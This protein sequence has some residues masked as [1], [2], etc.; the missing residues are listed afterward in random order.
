MQKDKYRLKLIYCMCMMFFAF[1]IGFSMF[2]TLLNQIKIQYSVSISQ[3]GMVGTM[4]YTGEVAALILGGV[5]ADRANKLTLMKISFLVFLCDMVLLG[6]GAGLTWL[7]LLSLFFITGICSSLLNMSLSASVSDI[8]PQKRGKYLNLLHCSFGAGSLLGPAYPTILL[9]L[10]YAWN[11]A[12]LSIGVICVPLAVVMLLLLHRIKGQDNMIPSDKKELC[13]TMPYVGYL[14]DTRAVLLCVI[15]FVCVGSQSALNTW[16]PSYMV[17]MLS[18]TETAAGLALTCYWGGT[19]LGR[20]I[21]S[22]VADRV[23]TFQYMLVNNLIGGA[24]FIMGVLSAK[25]ALLMV[26]GAVFGGLTGGIM[27]IGI[28]KI[29][30]W[31]VKQSGSATTLICIVSSMGGVVFPWLLGVIA[32]AAGYQTVILLIAVNTMLGGCLALWINRLN[33]R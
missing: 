2:G 25:P 32:D 1:A 23:N 27:P 30:S 12:Y 33:K 24:V 3:A 20:L 21:Y 9:Q 29:C 4:Q 13:E 18:V 5:I 31:Y 16:Y 7:F 10:G 14:S 11:Y 8:Y 17:N 6:M 28:E 22:F 19:V 15:C 26:S